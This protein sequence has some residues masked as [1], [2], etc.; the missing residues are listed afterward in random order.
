MAACCQVQLGVWCRPLVFYLMMVL[1]WSNPQD[2]LPEE[3][4]LLVAL[5]CGV[6]SLSRL[7]HQLYVPAFKP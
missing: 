5:P 7:H 6:S 4:G 1:S 2:Q 3:A